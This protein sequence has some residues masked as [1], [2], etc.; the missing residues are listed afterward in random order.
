MEPSKLAISH[1]KTNRFEL[2]PWNSGCLAAE[3]YKS[4]DSIA[5]VS[6]W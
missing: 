2:P 3:C 6:L 4:S 1:D 5:K